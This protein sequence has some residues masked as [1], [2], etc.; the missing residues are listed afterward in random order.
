MKLSYSKMGKQIKKHL[1]KHLKEQMSH[2]F[3]NQKGMTLI[4]IMIVIAILGGL[5]ALLA[6]KFLGQKDK[7]NVGQAK[8]QMGQIANALSMYYNDCGKF[9][10][11]LDNLVKPDANCANWGP[12]AYLKKDPVDPWGHAYVYE[13]NGSEYSLKCLGKDGREGGSGFAADIQYE[14]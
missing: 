4:E 11:S 3:T 1:N 8:I 7:A 13:L 2:S 10:Q 6:P 12:E 9:P 5:M 14:Q